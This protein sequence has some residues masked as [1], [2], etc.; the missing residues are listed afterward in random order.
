MAVHTHVARYEVGLRDVTRSQNEKIAAKDQEIAVLRKDY[1]DSQSEIANLKETLEKEKKRA[2]NEITRLEG[3]NDKL[4]DELDEL[5]QVSF[6][7]AE[8]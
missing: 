1:N 3:I 6:E 5:K 2:T 7:V 8:V 4:R